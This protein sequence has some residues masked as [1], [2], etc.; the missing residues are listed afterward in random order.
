MV[1][2]LETALAVL[3]TLSSSFVFK[4]SEPILCSSNSGRC[5]FRVPYGPDVSYRRMQAL[6]SAFPGVRLEIER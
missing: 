6:L 2:G 5:S 4:T 1:E 3:V